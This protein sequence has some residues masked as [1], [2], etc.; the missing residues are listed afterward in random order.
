M[1]LTEVY[2]GPPESGFQGLSSALIVGKTLWL[3]SYMS[4]RAAYVGL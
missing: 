1:K 4:D 2:R 3:G